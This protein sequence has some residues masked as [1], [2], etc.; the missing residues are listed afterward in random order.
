MISFKRARADISVHNAKLL[1]WLTVKASEALIQARL[2]K[3]WTFG[4]LGA[5]AKRRRLL[6]NG[7][8]RGS[9]KALT[10]V[11]LVVRAD[12]CIKHFTTLFPQAFEYAHAQ[13]IDGPL[14]TVVT[15]EY[16]TL[17]VVPT[18][19]GPTGAGLIEYKVK[20]KKRGAIIYIALM[21]PIPDTTYVSWYTGP[22]KEQPSS[23]VDSYGEDGA[24]KSEVEL[25]SSDN[26]Y[27]PAKTLMLKKWKTC[28]FPVDI[29][30]RWILLLP[31][32]SAIAW[33]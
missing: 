21:K 26:E 13:H 20:D 16:Q 15:K 24:V 2:W 22:P 12:Q 27:D 3:R 5:G 19:T 8:L 1:F 29:K 10:G 9:S 32:A 28:M 17:R 23:E 30:H 7:K 4:S 33:Q 31:L 25:N 18:S 14:Y 11:D 6:V